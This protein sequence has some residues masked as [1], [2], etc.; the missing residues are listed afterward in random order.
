MPVKKYTK[1]KRGDPEYVAKIDDYFKNIQQ[2]KTLY[3]L[4]KDSRNRTLVNQY[5]R[6]FN[7]FKSTYDVN[8]TKNDITWI[9][10]YYESFYDI[11]NDNYMT[12]KVNPNTASSYL[13]SAGLLL[14]HV[15]KN[16]FREYSRQFF[17]KSKEFK[18]KNDDTIKI[19]EFEDFENLKNIADQTIERYKK[20]KT[21]SNAMDMLIMVLNTYSVPMRNDIQDLMITRGKPN[22]T[23]KYF[24]YE[25]NY[26]WITNND[27]SS[28]I[29][30]DKVSSKSKF[31]NKAH[32]VD[33][34][35]DIIYKDVQITDVNLVRSL[36]LDTI[37][38]YPR[39]YLLSNI[40]CDQPMNNG[41]YS[42]KLKRLTQNKNMSQNVFRRSFISY[43]YP[44]VSKNTQKKI[45]K[46]M[47]HDCN[48]ARAEY[49]N[50]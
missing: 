31:R 34:Q 4:S 35:K 46:Y 13:N 32:I 16:R 3:E 10:K 38:K 33:Y 48:T 22:L 43:W 23:N 18:R 20:N 7:L 26:I 45:A 15:N 36:I 2:V 40:K 47:R 27:V 6:L 17:L 28:V 11:V 8:I 14:L 37:N 25:Q 12:D 39:K 50:T 9:N 44:R 19:K 24:D 5:S 21:F 30:Q 41:T 1:Y 29:N 42:D 49:L